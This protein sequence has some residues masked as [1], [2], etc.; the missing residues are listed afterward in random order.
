MKKFKSGDK[1]TTVFTGK[2]ICTVV[3]SV[4]VNKCERVTVSVPFSDGGGSYIVDN[5]SHRHLTKVVSA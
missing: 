2:K 5:V 4:F 3:G 1:V